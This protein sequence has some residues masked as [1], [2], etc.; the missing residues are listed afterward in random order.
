MLIVLQ[1]P[2][3]DL[4]GFEPNTGRLRKPTWPIPDQSTDFVRNFGAIVQRPL[5]GLNG[6]LGEDLVCNAKNAL[7][8]KRGVQTHGS[9]R[10]SLSVVF[11]RFY[12]DGLAVGKFEIGFA[13]KFPAKTF[14]AGE[15]LNSTLSD[16]LTLPVHINFPGNKQV[17]G[18]LA[19]IGPQLAKMYL[20]ATTCI[21]YEGEPR[22]SLV[23]SG[24]PMLLLDHKEHHDHSEI[25]TNF[26]SHLLNTSDGVNLFHS[27]V[28]HRGK[29]IHHWCIQLSKTNSNGFSTDKTRMLRIY[30]ERLHAEHECLRLTLRGIQT[31]SIE[32]SETIA[33]TNTLQQYLNE[34][35]R[36]IG[37][38]KKKTTRQFD[39]SVYEIAK[40]AT[41]A[42][43]PGELDA[44]MQVLDSL[45]LRPNIRS[46]VARYTKEWSNGSQEYKN[47]TY[48]NKTENNYMGD[49]IKNNQGAI[50]ATR[51]SI[52]EGITSVRLQHEE[53]IANSL[54]TLDELIA[55][56]ADSELSSEKKRECLELLN[57]LTDEAKKSSPTKSVLKTIGESLRG[58]LSNVASISKAVSDCFGV[59]KLLWS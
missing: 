29:H 13:S 53:S 3:L 56:V 42:I 5:R 22:S 43:R 18:E 47:V 17:S 55:S 33:N 58:S 1:I 11:R 34:A 28:S 31:K 41:S 9:R 19:E 7:R 50:F 48:Y 45:N 36:R 2:L 26:N 59:L 52:A 38:L 23:R 24:S 49:V 4:R 40:S 8:C 32:I 51:G 21:S 10:D 54:K 27:L 25:Q 35:T 20:Y 39:D 46:K 12:F 14:L 16:V 37:I 6:W 44:I 15:I 30:L 57:A